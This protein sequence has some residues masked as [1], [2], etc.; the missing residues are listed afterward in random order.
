MEI[1]PYTHTPHTMDHLPP[2]FPKQAF[3]L[4]PLNQTFLGVAFQAFLSCNPS[5]FFFNPKSTATHTP[6][7]LCNRLKHAHVRPLINTRAYTHEEEMSQPTIQ[8][9][10]FA[11]HTHSMKKC[12][13]PASMQ[14]HVRFTIF[15]AAAMTL[16]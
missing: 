10:F 5:S 16:T 12:A 1:S 11:L 15:S 2:T 9:F 13:F 6:H 14:P 3:C 8:C 7:F 4:F